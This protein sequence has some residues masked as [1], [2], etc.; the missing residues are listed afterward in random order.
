M[1]RRGALILG[2][3]TATLGCSR[4][5]NP[6]SQ[7]QAAD[8]KEVR[9]A[10]ASF[11]YTTSDF[12]GAET[13]QEQKQTAQELGDGV[14]EGVAPDHFCFFLGD[15]RPLPALER[16][17]RYFYPAHSFICVIPLEDASVEDFGE[18]YPSLQIAAVELREILRDRPDRLDD[19]R[20]VPDLPLNN[21]GR[22][23]LSRFQYLD[24]RSGSG[25][26]FLTQYSQEMEPNPV[27]NEELTLDFQGI[28][29][30]GKYYVAARLAITHPSL[31]SGIDFTDHIVRD[32][33][34][35]YLRKGEQELEAFSEES[36]EPSLERLK[37]LL[38]SIH[39]E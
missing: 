39:I 14:D 5:A 24:F 37:D 19:Q 1:M 8:L 38:S 9:N 6:H 2:T 3:A 26:L 11:T 25:I 12:A 10:G 32:R 4:S 15:K 34:Y 29:K 7:E 27:N 28:T 36:F 18:A 20:A 22:S 16:G 31:P 35:S 33:Q 30:D 17:S 23:I 13:R 21:A